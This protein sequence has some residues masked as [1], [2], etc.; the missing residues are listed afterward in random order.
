[1]TCIDEILDARYEGELPESGTD[2]VDVALL[3]TCEDMYR[4]HGASCF[5]DYGDETWAVRSAVMTAIHAKAAP[6]SD[7]GRGDLPDTAWTFVDEYMLFLFRS[8]RVVNPGES[9]D[10]F[11]I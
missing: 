5:E 3:M 11:T 7:K 6:D 8:N 2:T 9:D 10:E 1:M 4:K